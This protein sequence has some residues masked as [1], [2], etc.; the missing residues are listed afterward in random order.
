M[1]KPYTFRLTIYLTA[2]TSKV[3]LLYYIAISFDKSSAKLDIHGN[4]SYWL[5]V[6]VPHISIDHSQRSYNSG[7]R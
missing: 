7:H 6:R 3:E 4:P 2:S 1:L 5:Y